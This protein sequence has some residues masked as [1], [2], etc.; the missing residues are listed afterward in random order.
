[1]PDGA[2]INLGELSKPATVLIEKISGAVGVLYEPTRIRREAR[3]KADAALIEAES[4]LEIT[5]LER[6]AMGRFVHEQTREQKNIEDITTKALPHLSDTANPAAIDDDWLAEFFARSRRVSNQ[7]MQDLWARILSGEANKPESV[8]KRTLEFVALMDRADAETFSKLCNLS[9]CSLGEPIVF[10]TNDA[11][12]AKAGLQYTDL[13]HLDS[14]G[15]VQ[16]SE[17][18][19][20]FIR[21]GV[22]ETTHIEVAGRVLTITIPEPKKDKPRNIV[23]GRLMFTRTGRELRRFVAI[24]PVDGFY[25]YCVEHWHKEKYVLSSPIPQPKR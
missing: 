3:A 18:L 11:I 14:I 7:Q 5:D 10:D 19:A 1:M 9:A 6:R 25:D 17:G 20:T 4:V 16:L 24:E 13:A 22:G 8:S 23:F 2:L 15:L 12:L 21:Q